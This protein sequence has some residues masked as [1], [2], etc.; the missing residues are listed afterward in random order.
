MRPNLMDREEVQQKVR[1][2]WE[3]HPTWAKDGRKRW[4]LALGRVRIVLMEERKRRDREDEDVVKLQEQLNRCR[5]EMP[6]VIFFFAALKAKMAQENITTL[7]REDGRTITDQE[8][9]IQEVEQMYATL[10]AGVPEIEGAELKRHEVLQMVDRRLSI[11]QNEKIKEVPS[12]ELIEETVRSL[13]A[14][15][16]SGIDGVVVE[17]LTRGWQFMKTDCFLMVR[18]MWASKKLLTKDNRGLI[19]LIPKNE[20]RFWLT[21]WRPITLLTV[22]Y[23]IIAKI[24]ASRL[25]SMMPGLVDRQ[26]TGFIAG[27]DITENVLSLR[28]AQEWT[29]A[30]GQ[31]AIFVKLDFQK[32]YDRVLYVFLWETLAV[33]GI[34]I[35]LSEE[36]FSSLT[37]EKGWILER[38]CR[39]FLWGWKEHNNPKTALVAWERIAQSRQDGGLGWI[40]FR[41]KAA[42]LHI[43]CI[44]KLLTGEESEWTILAKSLI[45]RTLRAGAYQREICQW[46]LDEVLLLTKITKVRGSP[47]LSRMLKSWGQAKSWNSDR[48]DLPGRFSLTQVMYLKSWGQAERGTLGSTIT[49]LLRKGNITT[50]EVGQSLTAGGTSWRQRLQQTGLFPE[51]ETLEEINNLEQWVRRISI[52][53][54]RL[55]DSKGWC[56]RDRTE[57]FKWE[58]RVKTWP[59]KVRKREDF[60]GPLDGRWN[61]Q[62][63]PGSWQRRWTKLWEARISYRKK[64]W[65][66]KI[67]QRGFFTGS[68]AAEMR[69]SQGYCDRC[70]TQVETLE[71]VLWECRVLAERKAKLRALGAIPTQCHTLLSWIDATLT[72]ARRDTSYI[73]LLTSF[74]DKVWKERNDRLFNQK[75]GQLPVGGILKNTYREIDAFPINSCSA[76][77]LQVTRTAKQTLEQWI[78]TWTNWKGREARQRPSFDND[79]PDSTRS[80][81][82]SS[83]EDGDEEESEGGSS[84]TNSEAYTTSGTSS[85]ASVEE[86]STTVDSRVSA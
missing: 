56:W 61:I 78:H 62:G 25:N 8:E 67:L 43:K 86:E 85:V 17:I 33:A 79:R 45:L 51:E 40:K 68:C 35:T 42:A 38:L 80:A 76:A 5:R 34:S 3:D 22:T 65:L 69:V 10:Y 21:N 23:K 50:L 19:K 24:I 32:A 14:E 49:G 41:E 52:G 63:A 36:S 71:H 27:R 30:S 84:S 11:E 58:G 83:A 73:A 74:A 46:E 37:Q 20:D 13:P 47:T 66:W 2:T 28:L 4:A 81:G 16:A 6:Q 31:Q 44:L 77:T 26:Q 15:K 12:E 59:E 82:G 1:S 70:Q 53:N 29:Q 7:Q 18:K 72:E 75:I 54:G 64:V 60:S 39:Q 55:I 48:A 57:N 9:I